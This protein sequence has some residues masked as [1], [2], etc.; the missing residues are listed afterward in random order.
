MDI[1]TLIRNDHARVKK[2][3]DNLTTNS[4]L[5]NDKKKIFLEAL[6][7]EL[8]LH[9]RVEE[10]VFYTHLNERLAPKTIVEDSKSD[11]K[12]V[13]MLLKTISDYETDSPEWDTRIS[14]I[15]K[16]IFTH[17]EK[18][19]TEIFAK[20]REIIN[21]EEMKILSDMFDKLKRKLRDDDVF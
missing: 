14:E 1:F 8:N 16:A 6:R 3:I 2:I 18:E 20:A 11:H 15:K 10:K 5:N 13:E 4:F 12:N 21:E 9:N 7:Q 17:V 19:E